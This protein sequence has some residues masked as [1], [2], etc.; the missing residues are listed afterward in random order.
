MLDVVLTFLK[1]L[2][3]LCSKKVKVHIKCEKKSCAS[4]GIRCVRQPPAIQTT[5]KLFFSQKSG[6]LT[7]SKLGHVFEIFFLF[8]LKILENVEFLKTLKTFPT[9]V[10]NIKLNLSVIRKWTI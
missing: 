8:K 9:K 7:F 3:I 2:Q 10:Q 4:I 1:F 5:T 6:R